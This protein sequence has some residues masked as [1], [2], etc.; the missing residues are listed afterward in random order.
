MKLRIHSG[1]QTGADLAGLWVARSLGI[2][3]G[4]VAPQDYKTQIGDQPNLGKLF[5]LRAIAGGYRTRTIQNVRD[6][7]VTLIFARN[8]SSP[9]TVLT[10]N[11]CTRLSK[12]SFSIPDS[13][14]PSENL[15]QYWGLVWDDSQPDSGRFTVWKNALQ[16]LV[17]EAER[18]QRLGID[19]YFIIN[20]AG[21]ATKQSVPD[22]FEFTFVSLW[23]ML[24][25]YGNSLLEPPAYTKKYADIDPVKLASELK[26]RYDE[27]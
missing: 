23:Y 25:L 8:M 22:I 16:F 9:G 5:G 26:D 15:R 10:K 13:R 21:N 18:R 7:D 27:P 20:V 14:L 19:D 2:P 6:S 1:G 11:A 17:R 12:Q 24:M 3:T 4:G